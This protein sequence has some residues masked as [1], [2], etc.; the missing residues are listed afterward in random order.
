MLFSVAHS[1]RLISI[2]LSDNYLVGNTI[3]GMLGEL[4]RVNAVLVRLILRKTRLGVV[5]LCAITSALTE[6]H[7]S[8]EVLDLSEN[9]KL[10][11][12]YPWNASE[13][14]AKA[15]SSGGVYLDSD[16]KR[17][18][19]KEATRRQSHFEQKLRV[20]RSSSAMSL[21][22]M[23]MNEKYWKYINTTNKAQ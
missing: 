5:A 6:N 7:G 14:I 18:E 4:I 11:W 15:K 3:A 23:S 21:N 19:Q 1:S 17:E 16:E 13:S 20:R 12:E 22:S 10:S 8:L 2:D 9:E